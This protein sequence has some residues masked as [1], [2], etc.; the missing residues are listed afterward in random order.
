[1]RAGFE[2]RRAAAELGVHP[3]TVRYRM[4]VITKLTG[5]DLATYQ[6]QAK[7]DIAL[8]AADMLTGS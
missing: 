6:D 5:L 8:R 1:V 4:S 3:N 7:A 2:W